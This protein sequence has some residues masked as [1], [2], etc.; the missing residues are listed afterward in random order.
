M[1][2]RAHLNMYQTRICWDCQDR[3]FVLEATKAF[4]EALRFASDELQKELLRCF[5][6]FGSFVALIYLT[7]FLLFFS[8]KRRIR[9]HAVE[10]AM[11][12][13]KTTSIEV[14]F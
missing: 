5:F 1:G 2:G 12:S 9:H 4:G 7:F 10:Q 6:W 11:L 14:N 3:S 13:K 8:E